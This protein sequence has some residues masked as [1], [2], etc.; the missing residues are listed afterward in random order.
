MKKRI[1]AI[2]TTVVILTTVMSRE[3]LADYK[4][5]DFGKIASD[6]AEGIS[7]AA[8]QAGEA[9]SGAAEQAGETI[10]GAASQAG[11][12]ISQKAGDAGEAISGA[13]G[14]AGKMIADAASTTGKA[15]SEAAAHVSNIASGFA[16]QAG[17]V[18]SEWG[19][20]AGKTTDEIKENLSNAGVT[21][22]VTAEQL[23][24]ATAEKASALTENAGKAADDA[25]QAVSGAADYVVDQAG[26]VVDLAAVGAGYV[27]ASAGEAFRILQDQGKVLMKIAEDAVADIDLSQPENWETARTAVDNAIERAYEVGAIDNKKIDE[28]TARI[29]TSIVFGTMMYGYQYSNG[30][31]TLGE[32]ARGMSEIL[33]REGLPSGVGFVVALLPIHVP[34]ADTLAKEATYYLISVAYG[35]ESGKEIE[36]EEELLLAETAENEIQREET[37]ETE[38]AETESITEPM[39]EEVAE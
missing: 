20:Q 21:I 15:A 17:E 26:H 25:I 28:E 38:M 24:N 2:M 9:I 35:D 8:S 13:A 34:H 16:S 1:L 39:T 37:V 7:G 6:A 12:V 27:T 14:V 19:E 22:K 3:A 33:I 4:L 30:Q 18:L 5:P 32:Y 29:V 36:A 11:E 23:G 10:S 31:I